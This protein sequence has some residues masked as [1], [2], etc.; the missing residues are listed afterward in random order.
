MI[1]DGV[2]AS[3]GEGAPAWT[4]PVN[5]PLGLATDAFGNLF[6]TSSTAVRLLPA[7]TNGVVDGSG[8]VQTIYG[9]APRDT[10]PAY[11]TSCLTGIAVV[12]DVT[13]HAT[14]ACSGLLVELWRQPVGP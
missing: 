3:S 7:D 9:A 11:A 5:T 1:G 4:F 12:D 14:D 2:G 13:V 6:V 8:A 10:F